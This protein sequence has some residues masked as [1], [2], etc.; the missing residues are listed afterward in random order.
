M[1]FRCLLIEIYIY[2]MSCILTFILIYLSFLEIEKEWWMRGCTNSFIEIHQMVRRLITSIM[3]MYQCWVMVL[4]SHNFLSSMIEF[5]MLNI[6]T[7]IC[8]KL[9]EWKGCP[10]FEIKINCELSKISWNICDYVKYKVSAEFGKI[11][12]SCKIWHP[13]II[14]KWIYIFYVITNYW[15]KFYSQS[16]QKS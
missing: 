6:T 8:G 14:H 13:K 2:I 10:G 11:Y 15:R 7:S 12:D 5:K 4:V 1:K 3:I 16:I 9:F